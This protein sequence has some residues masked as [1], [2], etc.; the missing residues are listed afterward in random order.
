VQ[1]FYVRQVS[2][3]EN[4]LVSIGSKALSDPARGC[5]M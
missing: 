4:K 3:K 5:K 2:D 1:D